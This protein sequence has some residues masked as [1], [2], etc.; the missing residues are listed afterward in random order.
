MIS[1]IE[2]Q[3]MD[4]DW[5]LT[6]GEYIGFM[7]SCGGKL[8]DSVI[9]SEQRRQI[10]VD[11]FRN[12]PEISETL[13][14]PE[15]DKILNKDS[16]SGGGLEDYFFLAKKGLYSFDKTVLNNFFDPHYHLVVFPKNPLR[17]KDLSQDI[18]DI[19]VKT[20]YEG[21]LKDIQN[22]DISEIK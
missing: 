2:Q 15:L 20:K 16:G 19:I 3:T 5:F 12:L 13:I 14:N 11:Y 8:P 17:L 21:K 6:D 4:L 7:T 1:E 9:E 18:L 10:L 22:I